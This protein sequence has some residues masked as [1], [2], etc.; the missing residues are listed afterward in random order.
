MLEVADSGLAAALAGGLLRWH[1]QRW[2]RLAAEHFE[3]ALGERRREPA[4]SLV[5]AH[6]WTQ[7]ALHAGALPEPAVA[8]VA[9]DHLRRAARAAV[10][11][12]APRAALA[13]IRR[14][15][16]LLDAADVGPGVAAAGDSDT[17]PVPARLGR[18]RAGMLLVAGPAV[19]LVHG[20]GSPEAVAVYSA[21]AALV[22]ASGP[23]DSRAA[24]ALAGGCANVCAAGRFDAGEQVRSSHLM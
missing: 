16:G 9:A 22:P 1:R 19:M 20:P 11:G 7:A 21:L 15:Q 8:A 2:H 18:L 14:A 23:L 6:H 17:R 12:C 13:L 10:A 24:A 4:A 5:L 3:R